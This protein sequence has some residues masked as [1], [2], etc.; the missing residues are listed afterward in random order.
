M[1]GAGP[2]G[3][4]LC[5]STRMENSSYRMADL[6]SNTCCLSGYSLVQMAPSKSGAGGGSS[7]HKESTSPPMAHMKL[8]SKSL[9]LAATSPPPLILCYGSQY[10]S[11]QPSQTCHAHDHLTQATATSLPICT[12]VHTTH[13]MGATPLSHA[14]HI[15]RN[16]CY[17]FVAK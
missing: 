7:A 6:A 16:H 13:G 10:M 2:K 4:L 14:Q 1:N 15:R 3:Y 11:G 17:A 12:P 8:L 5:K 9:T